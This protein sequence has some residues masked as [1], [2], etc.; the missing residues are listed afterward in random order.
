MKNANLSVFPSLH[1]SY[2]PRAVGSQGNKILTCRCISCHVHHLAMI[3]I[4]YTHYTVPAIFPMCFTLVKHLLDERTR[5]KI[6][7]LGS[8]SLSV[9]C[10]R[11]S[12]IMSFSGNYK[13]ELQKYISPDQLPQAYGGTRCEPDPYCTKYVSHLFNPCGVKSR[14]EVMFVVEPL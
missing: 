1:L 9:L 8:E 4:T 7:F 3:Y 2:I 12:P 14:G 5:A 11:T 13:E 6:V 10:S